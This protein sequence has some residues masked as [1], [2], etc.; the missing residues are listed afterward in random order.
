MLNIING[1]PDI[2]V[3]DFSCLLKLKQFYIDRKYYHCILLHTNYLFPVQYFLQP[4]I[5][6]VDNSKMFVLSLNC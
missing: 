5:Q 3:P 1:V 2:Y 4:T 6:K